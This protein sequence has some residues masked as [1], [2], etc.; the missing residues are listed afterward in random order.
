MQDLKKYLAVNYPNTKGK[1]TTDRAIAALEHMT[2]ELKAVKEQQERTFKQYIAE[3][4]KNGA[5]FGD[6]MKI[7]KLEHT[8]EL[9]GLIAEG[10][11]GEA[12]QCLLRPEVVLFK[13]DVRFAD[14]A[15]HEK[16]RQEWYDK[17]KTDAIAAI[18]NATTP[19]K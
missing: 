5:H 10:K 2:E 8:L 18:Q 6:G 7:Q 12:I 13:L 16:A 14:D 3:M 4:Q 9:I 19:A 1:T 15:T 17:G 11:T